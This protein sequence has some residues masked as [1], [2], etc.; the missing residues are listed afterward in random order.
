MESRNP[1][2]NSVM[3]SLHYT[4]MTMCSFPKLF[5]Y[6]S[7]LTLLGIQRMAMSTPQERNLRSG[8]ESDWR[9]FMRLEY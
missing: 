4:G 6:R 3:N 2:E 1:G 7:G 5:I 9:S 8:R